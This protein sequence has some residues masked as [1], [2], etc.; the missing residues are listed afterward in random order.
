MVNIAGF[1][2]DLRELQ[3]VLSAIIGVA[4]LI[5]IVAF[6]ETEGLI[7][8]IDQRIF[9]YPVCKTGITN[10][11]NSDLTITSLC[12]F[13]SQS[14]LSS[15]SKSLSLNTI[16][17]NE[18]DNLTIITNFTGLVIGIFSLMFL[19]VKIILSLDL[20][21]LLGKAVYYIAKIFQFLS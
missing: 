8:V 9:G 11:L 19:L 10:P 20:V 21:L 5:N 6:Q 13:P 4:A 12:I 1:G 14:E 7:P 18:G 3:I 15:L 16:P 2:V 17:S